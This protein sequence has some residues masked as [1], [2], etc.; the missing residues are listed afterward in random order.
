MEGR[1]EGVCWGGRFVVVF[2]L[3]LVGGLG[4]DFL[5]A[6]KLDDGWGCMGGLKLSYIF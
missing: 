6:C 2:L 5:D 3:G 1:G 4:V